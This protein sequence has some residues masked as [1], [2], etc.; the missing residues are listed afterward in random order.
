MPTLRRNHHLQV[1]QRC[2]SSDL[3]MTGTVVATRAPDSYRVQFDDADPG[4]VTDWLDGRTLRATLEGPAL[5]QAAREAVA[6]VA[7]AVRRGAATRGEQ[8]DMER[9]AEHAVQID[10]DGPLLTEVATYHAFHRANPP[11]ATRRVSR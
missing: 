2:Y 6:E 5:A 4:R 8:I 7:A 9:A 1:G 3:D 11:R 10:F